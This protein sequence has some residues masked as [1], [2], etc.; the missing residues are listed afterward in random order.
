MRTYRQLST[1][2][3]FCLFFSF[4]SAAQKAPLPKNIPPPKKMMVPE[5]AVAPKVKVLT[6]QSDAEQNGTTASRTNPLLKRSVLDVAIENCA[7]RDI[8]DLKRVLFISE[9]FEIASVSGIYGYGTR[10]YATYETA[11]FATLEKYAFVNFIRGAV[12]NSVRDSETKEVAIKYD[13][14]YGNFNEWIVYKIPSWIIDA[15][16]PSPVYMSVEGFPSHEFYRW[17]KNV[18]PAPWVTHEER[19]YGW[20]KPTVPRLYVDD[21]PEFAHAS[22]DAAHNVSLE[23]KMCLYKIKDIPIATT[24]D[25]T[26]F[27]QPLFCFPWRSSFV[28]NHDLRKF[29]SPEGLVFPGL[30]G[31]N[32]LRVIGNKMK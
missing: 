27:A 14:A 8:C 5:K 10:L 15:G 2:F 16:G 7:D 28:Y 19:I 1:L 31:P 26:E 22:D 11:T 20:E 21:E 30:T 25:N 32:E 3:L 12:F 29:E 17:K 6:A 13:V 24:R 4:A 23:F 9:D 18:F